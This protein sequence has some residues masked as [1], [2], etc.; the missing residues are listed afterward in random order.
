MTMNNISV[1]QN[2]LI[3]LIRRFLG[4]ELDFFLIFYMFISVGKLLHREPDS[5]IPLVMKSCNLIYNHSFSPLA[6]FWAE[7]F[8]ILWTFGENR[9]TQ[10]KESLKEDKYWFHRFSSPRPRLQGPEAKRGDGEI[11]PMLSNF[12]CFIFPPKFF[13]CVYPSTLSVAEVVQMSAANGRWTDF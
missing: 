4:N 8:C 10:C 5:F 12:L 2:I 11:W 13:S 9:P 7:V 6:S 3:P 1:E